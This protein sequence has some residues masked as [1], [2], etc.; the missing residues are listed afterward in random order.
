MR[1]SC[2][3]AALVLA[4][5]GDDGM[6]PPP[7]Q[8]P[9]E[10]VTISP[11][12]SLALVA[13]GT[14]QLTATARDAQGNAL[15]GR[16]ISWSSTAQGVATVNT[17]G[18]AT[19]IV[20]GVAQIRAS[21][22]GKTGEVTITVSAFP[23]S[24]TG[25]LA[26]G[27][28]R[29]SATV[30]ANG[31]VLV[32]GGQT[33]GTLPGTLRSS[34]LYDPATGLWTSTG[35]LTTERSNH[36]AVRLQ[37]GKVLVAG[38]QSLEQQARLASAEL[39][40]PATGT[41]AT[42]GS[43]ATARQL[44]AV[45]RL[46]D[47][48]VMIAGGLGPNATFDPLSSVEIYN[49]ATGA[50]TSAASMTVARVGHSAILLPNGK[51]LVVGGAA[52]TSI[53]QHVHASSEVWDPATGQWAAS[54]NFLTAR[55]FPS[56]LLLGNGRPL[57]AGGSNFASTAYAATDLYDPITGG[58]TATGSM[59]TA[60]LS[61]TATLLPNGRVLVAGGTGAVGVLG[62][63]EVY[64]PGSGT[65]STASS[66]RV[67]R[68]NHAAVLLAN[69]KVLVVG[70]EGAGAAAS[71]EIFD[72]DLAFSLDTRSTNA[73]PA[74]GRAPEGFHQRDSRSRPSRSY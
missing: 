7:G 64:D 73:Q 5:N 70:G 38:G 41:W 46:A 54:G 58:W 36:I 52:G 20:A 4:C 56:A 23:W 51:V 68:L 30:L 13:G 8:T 62:S 72:P 42:T 55:A 31:K 21:S 6:S 44:A 66:L 57:I 43:M 1:W 61:H 14:T 71:T 16:L 25:S 11:G 33:L 3:P 45:V 47:G 60:R 18:L 12:P 2:L 35:S 24:A 17:S 32:T 22:E 53:S 48:R 50:W 39:Y 27:R 67:A 69:G 9:V 63:A 34:E 59:L 40:D 26:T 65:W 28:T 15:A 74:I 19:A 29:L 10:A 49:P 37:N